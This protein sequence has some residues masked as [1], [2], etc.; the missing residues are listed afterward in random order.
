MGTGDWLR[1]PGGEALL[2]IIPKSTFISYTG[3]S[4]NISPAVELVKLMMY[5]V[6]YCTVAQ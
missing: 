5:A 4:N 3:S 6:V 1:N 2:Q